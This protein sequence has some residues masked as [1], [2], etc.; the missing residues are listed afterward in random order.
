ME[1]GALSFLFES[2]LGVP[3]GSLPSTAGEA[4]AR[5]LDGTGNNAMPKTP[6]TADAM[7]AALAS[8][9]EPLLQKWFWPEA[10]PFA[11]FLSHDVDE[12]RWSWRRRLFMGIRHPRT[13]AG[14]NTRYWNFDQALSMERRFSVPSS[15]YFVADGEHRRDPPYALRDVAPMMRELAKKGAEVGVHGSF[16]SYNDGVRLARERAAVAEVLGRPIPG[17]RQH[18]LNFEPNVTW[19]LQ[20]EAGFAYDTSFALNDTSGFRAGMC[21]PFRPP[22]REILELP[23]IVMDGQLFWHERLALSQAIEACERLAG[24]VAARGGLLTLNW[25]Q[26]T[27]DA[28]SFPGWWDVYAHLLPWLAERTSLFLTGEQVWRWWTAREAVSVV[29]ARGRSG[30]LAWEVRSP[31]DIQGLS[32][33]VLGVPGATLAADAS[34][35]TETRGADT[36]LIL[37]DLRGGDPVTLTVVA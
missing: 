6:V 23:L 12:V 31:V 1:R 36:F 35:R 15:W 9:R 18:F 27:Y 16:L 26:H 28:L 11:V 34:H 13:L 22:G 24:E 21:H 2:C 3:A 33:R 8:V 7:T 20:E 25:H 32:L 4:F 19:R 29:P 10:A 5:I 14:G 30:K 37:S 17:L